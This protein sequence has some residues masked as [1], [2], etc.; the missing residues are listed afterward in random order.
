VHVRNLRHFLIIFFIVVL[1]FATVQM[2]HDK[3]LAASSSDNSSVTHRKF[4]FLI[5]SA[6]FFASHFRSLASGDVAITSWT[7]EVTITVLPLFHIYA[8][9]MYMTHALTI[10]MTLVVIQR[11]H[12]EKFLQLVEKYKVNYKRSS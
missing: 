7:D 2:F 9:E 8:I 11:F 3:P 12:R 5:S 1:E 10:G 6:T 4:F